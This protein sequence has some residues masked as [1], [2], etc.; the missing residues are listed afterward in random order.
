MKIQRV[1]N[2]QQFNGSVNIGRLSS[3]Q[4]EIL[5]QIMPD[6]TDIVTKK[7]KLILNIEGST[8]PDIISHNGEIPKYTLIWTQ[9]KSATVPTAK[10]VTTSADAGVWLAKIKN[11]ISEHENSD[12][13]KKSISKKSIFQKIKEIF[14]NRKKG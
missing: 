11:L 2:N 9:V 3:K 10:T 8:N 4:S 6:V 14:I 1:Q 12:F 7:D 5:K 13:Y